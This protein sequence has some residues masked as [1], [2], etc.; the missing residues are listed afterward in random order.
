M[1]LSAEE[2]RLLEQME[3]ALSEEDPKLASTMRGV[4][5]LVVEKRRAAIGVLGLVIGLALLILGMSTTWIVSVVGFVIMLAGTMYAL[6]SIKAVESD[7]TQQP[8]TKPKAPPRGSSIPSLRDRLRKQ[9]GQE[10]DH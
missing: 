1:A 8:K 9:M 7:K 3:A 6:R 5:S 2:Q 4:P 10:N